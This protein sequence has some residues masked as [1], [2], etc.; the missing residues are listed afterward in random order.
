MVSLPLNENIIDYWNR[1]M[2]SALIFSSDKIVQIISPEYVIFCCSKL[3]L[4]HLHLKIRMRV[5]M[6]AKKNKKT[7]V[8][9]PKVVGNPFRA[10]GVPLS[11]KCPFVL[12]PICKYLRGNGHRN[13]RE[14]KV[15]LSQIS[16]CLGA[17]FHQCP[18]LSVPNTPG[19]Q[20]ARYPIRPGAQFAQFST[21]T[22]FPKY[23]F[24]PNVNLPH[25][26][27]G[28]ICPDTQMLRCPLA[29]SIHL[30]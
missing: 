23:S 30:L 14:L 28:P 2:E 13:I 7:N 20:F 3:F 10:L 17:Y 24:F 22:H 25:L 1:L 29:P 11:P 4:L 12:V 19:A 26:Y 16:I 18:F 27:F 6:L 9:V 15:P 5:L 21:D 8:P